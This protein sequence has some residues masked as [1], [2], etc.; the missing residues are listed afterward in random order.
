MP[1]VMHHFELGRIEYP[2]HRRVTITLATLL[3]AG[4]FLLI[5]NQIWYLLVQHC[6]Q[7]S[8]FLFFDSVPKISTGFCCFCFFL[9]LRF[10]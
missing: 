1:L 8:S 7:A 5:Q 6:I 3:K 10:V 2:M 4:L 9:F